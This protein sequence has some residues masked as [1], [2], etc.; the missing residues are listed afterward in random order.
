M[1]KWISE[2]WLAGDYL[3]LVVR[4]FISIDMWFAAPAF[5]AS[6]NQTIQI[7]IMPVDI[8]IVCQ[9]WYFDGMLQ[10]VVVSRSDL[11]CSVSDYGHIV[12]VK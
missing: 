5:G 10:V 12:T 1:K 2:I 9:S 11:F 3:C 4:V 7:S 8:H 6:T